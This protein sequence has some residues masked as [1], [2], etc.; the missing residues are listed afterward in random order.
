MILQGYADQLGPHGVRTL[1]TMRKCE[2][3]VVNVIEWITQR[4]SAKDSRTDI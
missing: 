2:H 3:A 4:A 1:N